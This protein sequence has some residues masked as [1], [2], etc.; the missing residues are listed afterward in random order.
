MENKGN[1]AREQMQNHT[2]VESRKA[3]LGVAEACGLKWCPMCAPH[4]A[5]GR[6]LGCEKLRDPASGVKRS[7]RS[8]GNW[9]ELGSRVPGCMETKD[10]SF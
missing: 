2:Q 9:P 4:A 10:Y 6:V 8:L 7:V 1:S 3:Q 5:S